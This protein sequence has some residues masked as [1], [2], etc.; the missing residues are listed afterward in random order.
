MIKPQKKIIKIPL[1]I[2]LPLT[3]Q[4]KER[5]GGDICASCRIPEER[6]RPYNLICFTERGL[7]EKKL[8]MI[9]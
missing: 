8:N 2:Y 1:F 4:Q 5:K 9:R 6:S 7:N 3:E